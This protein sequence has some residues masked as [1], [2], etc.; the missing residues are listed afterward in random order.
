MDATRLN[1]IATTLHQSANRINGVTAFNLDL[2]GPDRH[3]LETI[4]RA[5]RDIATE[6]DTAG[7]QQRARVSLAPTT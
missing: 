2:D 3:T 5:L 1:Q 4:A 7:Y 6:L